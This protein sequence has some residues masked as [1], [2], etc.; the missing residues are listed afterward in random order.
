MHLEKYWFGPTKKVWGD[1]Q[2]KSLG[3]SSWYIN[4]GACK[5]AC[6]KWGSCNAIVV[7]DANYG[8]FCNLKECDFPVPKPTIVP[9]DG[10][11]GQYRATGK[12]NT[13]LV[14]GL[15]ENF[16]EDLVLLYCFC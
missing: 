13:H 7:K 1:D 4:I 15:M 2:C 10:W 11:Q 16:F 6:E 12:T 8:F 3:E 14:N 9:E 5:D